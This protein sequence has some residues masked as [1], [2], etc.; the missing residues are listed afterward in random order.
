MRR[1]CVGGPYG[2]YRPVSPNGG[3]FPRPV[4][5]FDWIGDVLKDIGN[6]DTYF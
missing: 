3:C 2:D 5:P 1:G 6:F 4:D